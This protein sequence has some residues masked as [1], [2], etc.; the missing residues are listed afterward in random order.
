MRVRRTS[1]EIAR[2]LLAGGANTAV[3]YVLLL[4][5]MRWMHYVIAYTLVYAVGIVLAYALQTRYV[6][7]VAPR[8]R[9]ALRFPLVYVAQYLLGLAV[10]TALVEATPLPRSWAALVT[11]A[12]TVP[13]GYLLSR[14]VLART[15]HDSPSGSVASPDTGR[16]A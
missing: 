14:L 12:A 16:Q 11:I 7:R 10:L 4:V 15:H 5:A 3:T 2:Y 9:T 13:A 1:G 8:W 6:F